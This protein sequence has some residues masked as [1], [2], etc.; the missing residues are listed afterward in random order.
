MDAYQVFDRNHARFFEAEALVAPGDAQPHPAT[1][2]FGRAYYRMALAGISEDRSFA[3]FDESAPVA[4]VLC[5]VGLDGLN[6]FGMPIKIWLAPQLGDRQGRRALR[7]VLDQLSRLCPETVECYAVSDTA[8][9]TLTW[10]GRQ[11]MSS[12]AR[13]E[14]RCVALVDLS[15]T[16]ERLLSE[17]R[18]RYRPLINWGRK[19]LV[20]SY[21]NAAS[22][23]RSMFE[24][25]REFHFRIAGRI[26]RP[27]SSWE[28]MFDTLRGGKGELSLAHDDTGTLVSSALIIDGAST[29]IYA[30]A[31]YDRDQFDKP[32]GHWPMFDAILRA[33]Q[34]G[35]RYFEV[36]EIPW[37]GTATQKEENIAF[38]KRGFASLFG[39][40]LRWNID[41]GEKLA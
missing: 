12:R 22:P 24:S 26:T 9:P 27:T 16:P 14:L 39:Y 40:D 31:V 1:G 15:L 11:L 25:F 23:D 4:F 8:G 32:L 38:F 30:S 41:R 29:A 2:T 18:S 28:V 33:R 20:M 34:R 5:S 17:V 19:K 10:F 13:P 7:V 21:V 37:V 3:I 35:M 6:Y 36:G